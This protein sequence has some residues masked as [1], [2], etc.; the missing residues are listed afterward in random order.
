[1][2][3]FTLFRQKT[4]KS[5]EYAV[6]AGIIL[7]AVVLSAACAWKYGLFAY[8]GIDL[9]YFNQVFWNTVRGRPFQQSIHPHLSLGDH[10]ELAIPLLAPLYAV[11]QDPRWLLILQSAALALAAW[12]LWRIASVR[13]ATRAVR[14]FALA[15]LLAAALWL[16][17]PLVHNI[18]LFEFHMLP[19]ALAPLLMAMLAYEEGCKGRFV[20]WLLLGLLVREDVAL[21]VMMMGL[22]AWMERKPLWWR[23][24]PALIGAGWFAAAMAL[25]GNFSPDGGYKYRI[26]YEWL[27]GTPLQMFTTALSDPLRVIAHVVTLPNF[28][29]MIGFLMPFAFLPLLRP[30]RLVL[31]IGPLAQILLGAPG[32]GE[33]V[34]QTH[35][36]TLFL[37]ALALAA[38]DGLAV[39]PAAALRLERHIPK[40]GA[41]RMTAGFVLIC[42]TYTAFLMGPLPSVAASITDRDAR[43]R[44]DAARAV[45]ADLPDDGGV[46]A[47]YALLPALSSRERLMSLHYAFLGVTQF[48]TAPYALPEDVRF[49]AFD[50]EDLLTY[51]TQ[52]LNTAWAAPH[53]DGGLERLSTTFGDWTSYVTPFVLFDRQAPS[54]GILIPPETGDGRVGTPLSDNLFNV[55]ARIVRHPHQGPLLFVSARWTLEETFAR[56]LT[57]RTEVRY[58]DGSTV[59]RR[60]PIAAMTPFSYRTIEG[61]L[62]TLQI[63]HRPSDPQPTAVTISLER[64]RASY[65]LDGMRSPARQVGSSETIDVIVTEDILI[66]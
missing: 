13:G 59:T 6:I 23:I 51:R 1:M 35:Y 36:A 65:V 25:I 16:L 44:A 49:Y 20:A 24:V 26:Y 9:A 41:G 18:A 39:A 45:I 50:V 66:K 42:V 34:L 28:E 14:A 32:G 29:M 54:Y 58:A 38:I 11:W 31:A 53:H 12:P 22:L 63:A 47:S 15:P 37:P 2:W 61:Y 62:T 21:V 64:E 55:D 30:R 3:P 52:F 5:H 40:T 4:P 19:F 17:N 10:A 8:D 43:Q 46:A 33:I 60:Q 27:G 57:M 48:G 7:T 56:D